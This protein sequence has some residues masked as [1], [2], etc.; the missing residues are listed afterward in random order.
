MNRT[1]QQNL[2]FHILLW[3]FAYCLVAIFQLT[4]LEVRV[5][6][7]SDVIGR[8]SLTLSIGLISGILYGI[9][10]YYFYHRIYNRRPLGEAVIL[11]TLSFGLIAV[12]STSLAIRIYYLIEEIPITVE[13]VSESFFT[14]RTLVFVFYSFFV[15]GMAAFIDQ[16]DSR[17][18]PGNLR[19][20]LTGKYYRPLEEDRIFMFL[21]LRSSTTIAE[22][23]GHEKYTGLIQDCFRNLSVVVNYQA[24]IY[25]YVGDEVVLSWPTKIGLKDDNCIRAFFAFTDRLKRHEDHYLK[26]YDYF[27]EFKAGLNMGSVMAAEIG[28]IKRDI[29]YFGDTINTAARIEEQCNVLGSNILVSGSLKDGLSGSSNFTF[30]YKGTIELKGKSEEVALYSVMPR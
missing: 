10:N 25:Q 27:P 14:F 30:E 5:V 20:L 22:R 24:E 12:F 21:D 26:H 3:S 11:A 15:A 16:V 9:S 18:G 7:L 2:V 13:T 17:F 28:E 1:L 6:T 19:K 8:L 23:I 29:Q 4:S